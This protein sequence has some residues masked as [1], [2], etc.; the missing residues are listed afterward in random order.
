MAAMDFVEP[1]Q[2]IFLDD[3][4]TVMHM[5]KHLPSKAPLT[6]ITN[7]LDRDQRRAASEA[8][9]CWPSAASTTTGAARSWGE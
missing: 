6:V 4:T 2:A 3:S 5:V 7:T 8:S 9:H 1:N